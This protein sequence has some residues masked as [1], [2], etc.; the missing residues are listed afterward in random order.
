MKDKTR[1]YKKR[2]EKQEKTRKASFILSQ[3]R[4]KLQKLIQ[5]D[6]M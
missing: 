4:D 6:K 5:L 2:Q 3:Q 1:K